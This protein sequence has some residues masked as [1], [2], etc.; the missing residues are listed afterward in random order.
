MSG[1]TIGGVVTLDLRDIDDY[2]SES[3]REAGTKLKN[4]IYAPAGAA[5]EIHVKARQM[6]IFQGLDYLR[7][8][9]SHL[10]SINVHCEDADTVTS[11][12]KALRVGT[13]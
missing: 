11:W 9:G 2:Y 3:E 8:H 13:F 1:P 6:P 4:L 7:R 10:G 5:V 12:V